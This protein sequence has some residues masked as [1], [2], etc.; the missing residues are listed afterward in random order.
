MACVILN[1]LQS[2][3]DFLVYP[4]SCNYY[5]YLILLGFVMI[6]IT[7]FLFKA[8][9]KKTG[10]GDFISSLAVSNIVISVLASIG[11][12][13]EDSDGIPMIQTDI[14][15]YFLATTIVF[16]LFWIFKAE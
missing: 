3:G 9:E 2:V 16:T 6:I 11:T 14:W 1:D 7:W 4:T 10:R 5:F 8:E 12:L 15:L 13:I